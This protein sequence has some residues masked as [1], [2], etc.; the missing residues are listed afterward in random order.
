MHS[1]QVR[2]TELINK[3]AGIQTQ[4]H[5]TPNPIVNS[6]APGSRPARGVTMPVDAPKV[7]ENLWGEV[8][9]NISGSLGVTSSPLTRRRTEQSPEPAPHR[10]P[11]P[12]AGPGQRAESWQPLKGASERGILQTMLRS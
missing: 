2:A 11:W 1:H 12:P 9:E 10:L 7:L 4:V 5:L 6:M 8:R 3:G